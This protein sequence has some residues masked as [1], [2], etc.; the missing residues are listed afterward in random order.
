VQYEYDDKGSIKIFGNYT[1]IAE[2]L[3]RA[4]WCTAD[5]GH[6]LWVAY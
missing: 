2:A 1:H 4:A 5:K 3:V 6:G